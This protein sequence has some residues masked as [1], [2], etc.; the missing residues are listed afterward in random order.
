VTSPSADDP[1]TWAAAAGDRSAPLTLRT[2]LG[3]S[4]GQFIDG[5]VNNALSIFLLFYV[6]AVCGLSGALAG[7]ALSIGM[8]VDA[9]MD[10]AIGALSDGWHSRLGRRLP[11]MLMGLVPIA[12]TFVLIFM[13]PSGVG[14]GVL[15]AWLTVLSILLRISTSFFI[16]PYSAVGAE[17]SDN[18][19]ERSSIMTWRWGLGMIGA[20]IAVALGFGVFL[21]GHDGLSRRAAYPPFALVLAGIFVVG[22]LIAARTVYTARGRLHAPS[23]NIGWLGARVLRGLLEAFRNHSFRILFIG[24]L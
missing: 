19:A 2:K 11:F 5:I 8:I 14:Q 10:P 3:Y 7:V 4:A 21:T 1:G 9:V 23:D 18:Y 24:A 13:L 15:F 17:L 22:G 16:L 6:T 20:A 12:V